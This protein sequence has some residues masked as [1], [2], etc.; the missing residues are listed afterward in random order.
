MAFDD[1][2]HSKA[3]ARI[4]GILVMLLPLI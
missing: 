1:A 2:T 4:T 3:R